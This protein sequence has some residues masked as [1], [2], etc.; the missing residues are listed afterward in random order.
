MAAR[1]SPLIQATRSPAIRPTGQVQIDPSRV[2]DYPVVL[3]D[4]LARKLSLN[5]ESSSTR[6]YGI[7]YNYKPKHSSTRQ[8]TVLRRGRSRKTFDLSIEDGADGHDPLSFKYYGTLDPKSAASADQESTFALVFD[9]DRQQFTLEPISAE[10][11]FNLTSGPGQ[12]R[13]YPQLPL[14]DESDDNDANA[15]GHFGD[16]GSSASDEEPPDD[17]NPYDYRHFLEQAKTTATAS[18]P[19]LGASPS[20][21]PQATAGKYSSTLKPNAPRSPAIPSTSKPKAKPSTSTAKS[22]A[23]RAS[24]KAVTAKSK[25]QAGAAGVKSTPKSAAIVT[26]S[27]EESEGGRTTGQDASRRSTD[28]HKPRATNG[29]G[30]DSPHIVIDEASGLEIDMGS[31]PPASRP[32]GRIDPT[33]FASRSPSNSRSTSQSPAPLSRIV[34]AESDTEMADVNDHEDSEIEALTLPPPKADTRRASASNAR[35]VSVEAN[36]ADEDDDDDA[37][38]Q[39]FADLMEQEL[40]Q[41]EEESE[42]SEEE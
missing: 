39:E 34:N 37:D 5:A 9:Q 14:L 31:P 30:Y 13:Q 10:L 12:V 8:K 21:H 36:G 35:R 6:Y 27:D 18:T 33:A 15:D 38:D 1:S 2:G 32:R 3:G 41:E 22:S 29:K 16:G 7:R 4:E 11:N 24:T 28:N 20:L 25:S 19:R 42:I 17:D 23:S 26:A 40:A